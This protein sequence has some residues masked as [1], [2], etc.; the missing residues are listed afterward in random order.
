MDI[1]LPNLP[2]TPGS[3]EVCSDPQLV[4]CTFNLSEPHPIILALLLIVTHRS[5]STCTCGV[6]PIANL[7]EHLLNPPRIP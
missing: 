2:G 4:P 1:G 5:P 6:K 7:L 3:L